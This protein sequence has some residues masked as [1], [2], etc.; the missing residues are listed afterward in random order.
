MKWTRPC[1]DRLESLSLSP[2]LNF[3]QFV[4]FCRKVAFLRPNA[5]I[6]Y[7]KIRDLRA[8]TFLFSVICDRT[9]SLPTARSSTHNYPAVPPTRPR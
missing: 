2:S 6:V 4:G 7:C 5:K 3:S 9:A 1:A 8:S